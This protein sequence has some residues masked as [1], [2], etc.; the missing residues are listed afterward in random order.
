MVG[1]KVLEGIGNFTAENAIGKGGGLSAVGFSPLWD[2]E[3][4]LLCARLFGARP[5]A[6][7]TGS[8]ACDPAGLQA[9]VEFTRS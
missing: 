3:F 6:G 5:R 9:G 4:L 8:L 7:R 2:R 1:I